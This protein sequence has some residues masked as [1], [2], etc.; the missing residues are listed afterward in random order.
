MIINTECLVW[1]SIFCV[2]TLLLLLLA[3][4][5]AVHCP[6]IPCAASLCQSEAVILTERPYWVIQHHPRLDLQWISIKNELW[7]FDYAMW[8]I[9]LFHFIMPRHTYKCIYPRGSQ[10]GLHSWSLV[11]NCYIQF[12]KKYEQDRKLG[13]HLIREVANKPTD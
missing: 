3:W 6:M 1:L 10:R 12:T 4:L 8:N 9:N 5:L 2:E 11:A 7:C 13:V